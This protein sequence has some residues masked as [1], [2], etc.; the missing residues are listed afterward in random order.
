MTETTGG[1]SRIAGPYESTIVGT[2]GRLIAHCEAKIVDPN[3]GISLPPMNP[4]E[5]W[6]RGPFIMKGKRNLMD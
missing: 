2:V 1:V 4:G 5:L 6:V 3:T